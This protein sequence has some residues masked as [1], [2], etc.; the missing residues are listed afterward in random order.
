M[1]TD[2]HDILIDGAIRGE[3][4]I[5]LRREFEFLIATNT[6]FK[7][8]FQF[9]LQLKS[10]MQVEQKKKLDTFFSNQQMENSSNKATMVVSLNLL[11]Q[12]S[13]W[14]VAALIILV[15]GIALY[16]KMSFSEAPPLA[17]IP[18]PIV[19]QK[20]MLPIILT[21]DENLG[22]AG[23]QSIQDSL[24]ILV[25]YDAKKDAEYLFTDT[26]KLYGD[27]D[28]KKIKI[29]LDPSKQQYIFT[30]VNQSQILVQFT[31]KKILLKK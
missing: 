20:T 5:V 3:L 14:A 30:Y 22:L 28:L 13:R 23:K 15:L 31:E 11:W 6:E 4:N 29:Q 2:E 25:F 17:K 10:A 19:P 7:K 27:I 26:L 18:S 16:F 9:R 1:N 21:S 24:A 12:K 8:N